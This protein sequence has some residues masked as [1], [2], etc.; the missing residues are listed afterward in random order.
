MHVSF[1]TV[2]IPLLMHMMDVPETEYIVFEHE[3]FDYEQENR[4]MEEK[5]EKTMAAF[6]F[7]ETGYCFDTSPGRIIYVY[8]DPERFLKYIRPVKK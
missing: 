2:E 3:P 1:Q 7:A 5:I 8:Y 4:S 6:D